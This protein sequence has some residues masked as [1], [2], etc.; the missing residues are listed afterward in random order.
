MV[1]SKLVWQKFEK[2]VKADISE[3]LIF[4]IRFEIFRSLE[5]L[6]HKNSSH[7]YEKLPM[8]MLKSSWDFGYVLRFFDYFDKSLNH[9]CEKLRTRTASWNDLSFCPFSSRFVIF[10]IPLTREPIKP[11][12]VRKKKNR[13][14]T[15]LSWK[16]KFWVY[17]Q[18]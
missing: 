6:V 3:Y 10:R 11:S 5:N 14:T 18:T 13:K 15:N 17:S 8:R 7:C 4:R 9:C 16:S 12:V 2:F 1:I